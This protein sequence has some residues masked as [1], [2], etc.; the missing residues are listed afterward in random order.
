[1]TGMVLLKRESPYS[2]SSFDRRLRSSDISLLEIEDE[3]GKEEKDE[4][5]IF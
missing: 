2:L 1:M 5:M 4:V 3:N